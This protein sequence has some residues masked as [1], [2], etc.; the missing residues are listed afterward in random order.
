MRLSFF[1]G[2]PNH[3][4][5]SILARRRRPYIL[6]VVIISHFTHQHPGSS[7]SLCAPHPFIPPSISSHP[8]PSLGPGPQ[9]NFTSVAQSLM[10]GDI[11][12]VR[13]LHLTVWRAQH[14]TIRGMMQRQTVKS[15]LR[16]LR[17][18]AH[19]SSSRWC[20]LYP[21]LGLRDLQLG[22]ARCGTARW[23]CN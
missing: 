10:Y 14:S 11:L 6:L 16:V 15:T 4:R 3:F 5:R 8:D 18:I 21:Q 19:S 20:G 9:R 1:P 22:L 12:N 23:S 7:P 13:L 17:P 2:F